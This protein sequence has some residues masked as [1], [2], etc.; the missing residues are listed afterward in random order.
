MRVKKIT[1][2][3]SIP[4]DAEDFNSFEN[5]LFDKLRQIGADI[6]KHWLGE[7]EKELIKHRTKGIRLERKVSRYLQTRFGDILISRWKASQRSTSGRKRRYFFLLDR[8]IGLEKRDGAAKGL[9]RQGVELATD[10]TY[11]KSRDIL[12]DKSSSYVSHRRI[13]KWVQQK[14]QEVVQKEREVVRGAFNLKG[15]TSKPK[16]QKEV[17]AIEADSTY[18]SSNEGKG[19]HHDVKLGIIY[20]KKK[21]CGKNGT[22]KHSGR[23][24]RRLIILDKIIVAGIEGHTYFGKALWH[25]SQKYYGVEKAKHIL[26][27]ADGDRWLKDIKNTHFQGAHY[28]LDLWH[29]QENIAR[30]VGMNNNPQE[31]NK[32]IYTQRV[33]TLTKKIYKLRSVPR[34]KR[35]DLIHYINNNREG[36]LK[37]RRLHHLK[38]DK[39]LLNSGS[40]A[41][42]KNI[43]IY[44]GRRFKKQGMHWSRNGGNRLL[45]LRVLKLEPLEWEKLWT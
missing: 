25:K 7:I 33:G 14:G 29:L 18:I 23:K 15:N 16:E 44:I 24:R 4:E 39:K 20:T 38:I 34:E 9:K 37:F 12:K 21:D 30:T 35:L 8:H 19:T 31:L 11:R 1:L 43:E 40:G 22:H 5:W 26:Y 45:K 13:H 17:V 2:T 41:I 28:Q 32:H 36:I 6:T 3:I 42:E 27:Q 10:H